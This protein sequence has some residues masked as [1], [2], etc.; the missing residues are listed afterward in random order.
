MKPF[1]KSEDLVSIVTPCY[2]SSEF[3]QETIQ[4]VQ[5]QTH[6]K[7]QLF[8]ID[9]CSKDNST[10]LIE[11]FA[12][13]DR[14]IT[15]IR[16]TENLGAAE[17]RNKGLDAA[18]GRFIAFLDSDD[19]WAPEKL[20]KQLSFMKTHKYPIVFTAYNL[21]DEKGVPMNQVI[22]TVKVLD[23]HAYLKNTIIGMS[24]SLIDRELTGSDFRFHNIRT[25][26]DTYL[27]ISLLRDGLKAYG[28]NEILASYR[29]RRNSI[30]SN[31]WKAARRTWFVYYELEKL[32]FL[33][34]LYYFIYYLFNAIKK[35]L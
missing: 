13:S 8:I 35:R 4:S 15:L 24:T 9:D 2:N 18:E 26:Q 14:R 32:G 31:K 6:T 30:S 17:T 21:I 27:W 7:W 25:R 29:V 33:K 23:Y 5:N 20:E 11:K 28:M 16:N 12:E 22:N 10:E 1:A 34:S 19:L 3:I